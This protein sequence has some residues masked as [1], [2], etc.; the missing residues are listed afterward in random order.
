MKNKTKSNTKLKEIKLVG[1]R[2]RIE[3]ELNT[4]KNES[5]EDYIKRDE[6]YLSIGINQYTLQFVRRMGSYIKSI[7]RL[8]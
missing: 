6:R 3:P 1:K 7:F 5:D 4:K 2:S 8:M